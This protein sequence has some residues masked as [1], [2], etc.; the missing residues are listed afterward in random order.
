MCESARHKGVP[1][2]GTPLHYL[3]FRDSKLRGEETITNM[4]PPFRQS[5]TWSLLKAKHFPKVAGVRLT[6]RDFCPVRHPK[7]ES[8]MRIGIDLLDMMNIHN[9]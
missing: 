3:Q 8:G 7:N 1:L 6:D 9:E 5:R 2:R 4:P